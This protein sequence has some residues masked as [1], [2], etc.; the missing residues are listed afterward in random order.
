MI[1]G[2]HGDTT[3]ILLFDDEKFVTSC[4][5]YDKFNFVIINDNKYNK[6]FIIF[7][8]AVHFI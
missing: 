1:I 6:K 3:K 8:Q 7:I 4:N 5:P 2:N